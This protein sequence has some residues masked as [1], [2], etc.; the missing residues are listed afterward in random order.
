[1]CRETLVRQEIVSVHVDGVSEIRIFLK[2]MLTINLTQ[3]HLK[4]ILE[5]FFPLFFFESKEKKI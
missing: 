2:I 1:M 5:C 3:Y 4:I